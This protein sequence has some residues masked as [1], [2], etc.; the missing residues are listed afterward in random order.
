MNPLVSVVIPTY[1]RERYLP[2]AIVSV[3]SQTYRPIELIIIDDGSDDQTAQVIARLDMSAVPAIPVK[4]VQQENSGIGAARNRGVALANGTLLAFLDSD[5]LWTLDKLVWQVAALSED[6]SL[7]AVFGCTQEFLSA[8]LDPDLAARLHYRASP[9]EAYL[10]GAILIRRESFMRVGWFP[11]YRQAGE[12]I[13]WYMRAVDVDVPLRIK[14]LADTVLL[15]RL[16]NTNYGL[17]Q[18]DTHKS[19]SNKDIY[20]QYLRLLKSRLDRRRADDNG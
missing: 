16:H 10:A 12:F 3:L 14:M 11:E 7:D 9:S 8:D 5:D 1:N 4:Y 17:R 15:R 13:E 20:K 2:E 6:A 19:E 18:R